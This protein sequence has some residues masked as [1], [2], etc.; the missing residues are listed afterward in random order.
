MD[1]MKDRE[2]KGGSRKRAREG[3]STAGGNWR[4]GQGWG[5]GKEGTQEKR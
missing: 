5:A 2:K 1:R 3:T 4:Y